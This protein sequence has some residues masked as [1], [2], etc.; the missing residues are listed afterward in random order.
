[1]TPAIGDV[2]V[3][4]N[5]VKVRVRQVEPAKLE[6]AAARPG[7]GR[8]RS[9]WWIPAAGL[10]WDGRAGVWREPGLLGL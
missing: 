6:V 5:G 2:I 8:T 1:M 10:A 3:L 4:D 7:W 9:T